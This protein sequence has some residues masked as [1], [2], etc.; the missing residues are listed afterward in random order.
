L[1]TQHSSS[2]CPASA[3]DS[4]DPFQELGFIL[5]SN[6]RH[7]ILANEAINHFNMPL[8]PKTN[9][10]SVSHFI[11]H[12]IPLIQENNIIKQVYKVAKAKISKACA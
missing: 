3:H 2:I 4:L 9:I 11:S 6:S 1:Q 10:K 5:N 8:Y 12:L 7:I